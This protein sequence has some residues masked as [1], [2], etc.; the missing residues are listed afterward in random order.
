MVLYVDDLIITGSYSSMIHR[1]K[2]ALMGQFDMQYIVLLHY[3]LGL[4]V[5]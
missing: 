4:Q 2:E 3:F 5:L 1:V